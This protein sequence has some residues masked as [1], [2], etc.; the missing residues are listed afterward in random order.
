MLNI[1]AMAGE[2]AGEQR[3]ID[4]EALIRADYERARPGDSWDDLKRRSRFSK[5]DKGLLRHWLEVAQRRAAARA[6]P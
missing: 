2:A 4:L 3:S 5:R 1:A 6:G